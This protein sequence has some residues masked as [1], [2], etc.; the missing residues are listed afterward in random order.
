LGGAANQ[1]STASTA[2]TVSGFRRAQGSRLIHENYPIEESAEY[3]GGT[4]GVLATLVR[5]LRL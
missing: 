4:R 1:P 2:A 3:R 5:F